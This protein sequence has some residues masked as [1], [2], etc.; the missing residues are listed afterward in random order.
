MSDGYCNE[1]KEILDLISSVVYVYGA[2]PDGKCCLKEEEKITQ[3][4]KKNIEPQIR[5]FYQIGYN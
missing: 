1:N 2:I 5:A 4:R 3:A